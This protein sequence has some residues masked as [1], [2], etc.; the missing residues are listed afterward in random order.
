MEYTDK[1]KLKKPSPE[2]HYNIADFNE[3]ADT[4]DA[5]LA[6]GENAMGLANQLLSR[7]QTLESRTSRINQ[8]SRV[9]LALYGLKDMRLTIRHKA[10]SDRNLSFSSSSK[11]N[12]ELE[13]TGI[14]T[15]IYQYQG[16]SYSKDVYVDHAGETKVAL[17]PDLEV[18]DWDY[19]DLVC[20]EGLAEGCW[21]VG[22]TKSITIGSEQASVRILDFYHDSLYPQGAGRGKKAP[23]TFGLTQPLSAKAALNLTTDIDV[24]WG[25]RYMQTTYLP[26]LKTQLDSKLRQCIK[27]AAKTTLNPFLSKG[28]YSGG[29]ANEG[30]EQNPEDLFL[31]SE[32][33]IFG[34]ARSATKYYQYDLPYEYYRR[35]NSFIC[36]QDYWLRNMPADIEAGYEQGVYV[37]I[38]GRT[39]HGDMADQHGVLFGFCV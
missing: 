17:A 26:N 37:D 34:A 13:E 9:M 5:K 8:R 33:E 38:H 14:W 7:I 2:D 22:D 20:G 35:G 29:Y 4:I 36:N 12:F 27:T 16:K 39:S 28:G 15:L 24:R 1:Y 11:V 23:I 3:N 6:V 21:S 10:Y 18:V 32:S 25:E 19:I 31:L 30:A